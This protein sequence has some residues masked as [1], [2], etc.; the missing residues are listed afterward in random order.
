LALVDTAADT[1]DLPGLG[2]ADAVDLA[3][4]API[5][6]TVPGDDGPATSIASSTTVIGTTTTSSSTTTTV[7]G[8]TTGPTV[9]ITLDTEVLDVCAVLTAKVVVDDPTLPLSIISVRATWTAGGERSAKGFHPQENASGNR[10]TLTITKAES[11][12]SSGFGAAH[13]HRLARDG[14]NNRTTATVPIT[15]PRELLTMGYYT[16]MSRKVVVGVPL[17][18]L[19]LVAPPAGSPAISPSTA[20]ATSFVAVGAAPPPTW[21]RPCRS[22]RC[23]RRSSPRSSIRQRSSGCA[24]GKRS[25]CRPA[26]SST[27]PIAQGRTAG[28]STPSPRRDHPGG[29]RA[30]RNR[31]ARAGRPATNDPETPTH[32]RPARPRRP[33]P[34]GTVDACV[35]VPDTC[36]GARH[37]A[38]PAGSHHRRADGAARVH[39]DHRVRRSCCAVQRHRAPPCPTRAVPA[40]RPTLAVVVNQPSTIAISGTWADGS[41][42]D[43]LTLVTSPA[44]D[45]EW[46]QTWDQQ[47]VQRDILACITLGLDDVRTHASNGI[48]EL[49][50]DVL[51]ISAT[52]RAQSA[53]HAVLNIPVAADRLFADGVAFSDVGERPQPMACCITVHLRVLHR[54]SP[55]GSPHAGTARVRATCWWKSADCAAGRA[56]S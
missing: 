38:R 3:G 51:A 13:R 34:Q 40:T 1:G 11:G 23:L 25:T 55:R 8:D 12:L 30:D 53:G 46:R 6:S 47:R 24:V 31:P 29:A 4:G 26:P 9:Q 16:R 48:A 52:G 18:A 19:L 44:H 36:D 41:P 2:C 43:K 22:P 49:Q 14:L 17:T 10:F 7:A 37:G 39:T 54:C 20:P 56:T 42:M 35:L 32:R 15:L 50:A 33:S 28:P 45:E 21:R 5:P 27:F